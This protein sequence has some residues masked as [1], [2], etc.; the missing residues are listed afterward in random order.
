MGAAIGGLVASVVGSAVS[1][2]VGSMLSSMISNFGGGNIAGALAN[3]FM[4]ALG[5]ALNSVIDN[6][7][8]PQFLKD[9]A[10]DVIGN[11]IGGNQQATTPEAQDA[12]DNE[13]GDML[14]NISQG[15]CKDAAEKAEGKEGGNWLVALARGL[16]E[17]QVKFLDA[18]MENM[19]TMKNNSVDETKSKKDQAEDR[20]EFIQAQSEYQANMQMFNMMANMTATSLKSLGEG[21]TAIARKQ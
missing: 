7:P 4:G 5:N 21:L 17:V 9:A 19:D 13:Y 2:V 12:V 8:L 11:V 14:D 15:I 10:K 1:S 20:Q 3:A 18:A 6:S 16:S